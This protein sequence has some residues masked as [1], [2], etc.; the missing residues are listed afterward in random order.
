MDKNY[1][2]YFN[3]S[4]HDCSKLKG[5]CQRHAD[6]EQP[7]KGLRFVYWR[8]PGAGKALSIQNNP[9]SM[10]E[11]RNNDTS[12]I[13]SWFSDVC[14]SLILVNVCFHNILI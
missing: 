9:V 11:N 5:I 8:C 3:P 2:F 13:M 12:E 1:F 7:S 14:F 6:T 4:K 10:D